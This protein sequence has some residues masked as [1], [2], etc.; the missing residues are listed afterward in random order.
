MLAV[1][2]FQQPLQ[3]KNVKSDFLAAMCNPILIFSL[4][5]N[6]DRA[7]FAL[8]ENYVRIDKKKIIYLAQQDW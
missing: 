2:E 5:Y 4:M 3:K 1:T 6:R 7:S 8:W